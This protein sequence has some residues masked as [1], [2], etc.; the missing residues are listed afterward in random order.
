MKIHFYCYPRKR[1]EVEALLLEDTIIFHSDE[2]GKLHEVPKHLAEILNC[3]EVLEMTPEFSADE[4]KAPKDLKI[5]YLDENGHIQRVS[6]E[7]LDRI[8]ASGAGTVR[9]AHCL[10]TA[11]RMTQS[12]I[13]RASKV[14]GGPT[15]ANTEGPRT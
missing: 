3:P 6:K 9:E 13:S 4:L 12:S 1:A 11:A 7:G 5:A 14:E 10:A 15:S 2:N 8:I